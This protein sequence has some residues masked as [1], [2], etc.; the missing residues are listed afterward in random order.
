MTEFSVASLNALDVK[1][2]FPV[3]SNTENDQRLV[4]LDTAATSQ[5]PL[6]VINAVSD[7]YKQKNAN[8]HRGIYRLS[9]EATIAFESSRQTVKHFINANKNEEIIFTKGVTDAMNL[10]ASVFTKSVLQ[11]GD[12]VLISGMDHHSSIVPWQMACEQASAKLK[13]IPVLEDGTLDL[14]EYEK[15]LTSKTKIVSLIHLSNVLGIINPVKEMI[16]LAHNKGIP[17]VLDGAQSASHMP[18]D[19]QD[20]D[21]DFFVFSGHKMYGPTGVGI[22]YGKHE[23][24]DKLPPYQ[25]GG[26]MIA[27]VSFDATEYNVLPYK[28]EAGTPNIAG[29]IGLGEAIHFLTDLDFAAIQDHEEDLLQYAKQQL[30]SVKGL[31]F[32][33]ESTPES[34]VISFTL[35]HA[36]PHD[37]AT[38]LDQQGVAIRAGHHCAMPLMERF[39]V[40]ATARISFGVYTHRSDIDIAVTALNKVVELFN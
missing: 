22:L 20:L 19:V 4:Y 10:L 24:L 18:I 34:S 29:V 12:E 14:D 39:K 13:V 38:I 23:W 7:F 2:Q 27:K 6:R 11:P 25:G 9:H 36:H 8:V 21:C 16:K 32:L 26:D 3:L 37:I 40:P 31:R 30:L 33:G 28:F 35:D 1:Q 17:V 5:K 15:L